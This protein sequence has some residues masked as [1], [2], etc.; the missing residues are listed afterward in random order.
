MPSPTLIP[1]PDRAI[2]AVAGAD[3]VPFMQGL[4]SND[5]TA[6]APD[7]AIWA[8]L[9]T[10]QG[11]YLHDFI[12]FTDDERLLLDVE[13]A[14]RDDLIRR[15]RM[16]RLRSKVDLV[17]L[18]ETYRVYATLDAEAG[19][20][21]TVTR[22]GGGWHIV[23]P[24][25][26]GMGVRLVLPTQA[27]PVATGDFSDWDRRRLRLGIPDGSRDLT[28][29][30]SILLDNGFDE[31]HG[32]SWD[33]GCYVGQELTAR[34]KYRGLVKKRLLPVTL[35][36]IAPAAGTPVLAGT[37]EAGEIRSGNATQALALLRL[38]L[39]RAGKELTCDG[40]SVTPMPPDWINLPPTESDVPT[41]G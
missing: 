30:K 35:S 11:K 28:P 13:A 10:A 9:L 19:P 23:D 40:L 36:G 8:A 18:S 22:D 32:V 37:V 24:R 4:V 21:G 14:R 1:L 15:L 5:V 41:N 7:R 34:T 2:I 6:V 29:E 16:Y 39:L 33:K 38:D 17:D 27:D 26:A 20:V 12:I 25:H 31:L 3:R